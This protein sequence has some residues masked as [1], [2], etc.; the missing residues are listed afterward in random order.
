MTVAWSPY[1]I[2]LAEEHVRELFQAHGV[3][4]DPTDIPVLT[5]SSGGKPGMLARMVD[6]YRAKEDK[7]DPFFQ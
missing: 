3:K 4:V 7:E 5:V 6:N 2:N 1:E